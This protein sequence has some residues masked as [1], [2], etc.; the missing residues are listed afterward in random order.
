MRVYHCDKMQSCKH[1]FLERALN[2]LRMQNGIKLT[3]GKY[4]TA[5]DADCEQ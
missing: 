5:G 3:G 4:C 2:K 1:I